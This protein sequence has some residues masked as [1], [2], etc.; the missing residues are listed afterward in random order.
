[1]TAVKKI[2]FVLP[3]KI[4]AHNLGSDL[5]RVE[6]I[7]FP[8][9][10]KFFKLEEIGTFLLIVPAAEEEQIS[11]HL[12][13]F[14]D[15]LK[16]SVVPE[17]EILAVVPGWKKPNFIQEKL[18]GAKSGWAQLSGWLKQQ[19]LKMLAAE[20]IEEEFFIT[21]D[22]DICLLRPMDMAALFYNGKAIFAD[23]EMAVHEEWWAGAAKVL[24]IPLKVP[25]EQ[26]VISVT[27]EI[28]CTRVVRELNARLIAKAQE[29]NHPTLLEYLAANQPWSEYSLYWLYLLEFHG[30]DKYYTT[31]RHSFS[32]HSDD[33]L[34]DRNA[35]PD[36]SAV[37]RRIEAAFSN[38]KDKPLFLIIQSAWFHLS[39]Y[40]DIVKAWL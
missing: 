17:E 13:P 28:L 21:L 15:K 16:L 23:E 6:K 31:A 3:L 11:S 18:G 25:K 32:L 33:C 19:V 14:K 10:L 12:A 34:W 35:A 4:N 38:V 2:S 39:E 30:Q 7:L 5:E 40:R 9:F 22:A 26:L 24:D 1:M 8:T 36:K 37:R 20:F 29:K 27:P